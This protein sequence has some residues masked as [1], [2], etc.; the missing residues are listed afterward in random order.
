M[1]ENACNGD[2][3]KGKRVDENGSTAGNFLIVVDLKREQKPLAIVY[4]VY[5]YVYN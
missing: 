3:Y 4:Y 1:Q 5:V 2:D